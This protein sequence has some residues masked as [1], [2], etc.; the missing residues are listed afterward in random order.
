[1]HVGGLEPPLFTPPPVRS[2]RVQEGELPA[3]DTTSFWQR[4]SARLRVSLN[5]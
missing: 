3:E 1:V 4:P 5:L 2:A